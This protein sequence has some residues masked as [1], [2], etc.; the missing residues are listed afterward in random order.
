MTPEVLDLMEERRKAKRKEQKYSEIGR[1]KKCNEA[2][3]WINDQC[4]EIEKHTVKDSKYKHKKVKEVTG[5]YSSSR[6]GCL[7]S[8]AVQILMGKNEI[9]N[10]WSEYIGDLYNDERCRVPSIN[11]G[12]ESFPIMAK[13]VKHALKKMKKG[14]AAGPGY[15]PIELITALHNVGIME[16]M[17]VDGRFLVS[18][19][20]QVKYLMT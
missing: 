3:K 5:K 13:E 17:E 8:K 20:T 19:T 6:M 11:N 18:Y 15:V 14:K 1:Q 7:Q 16:V 9:S 4:I 10:R 2:E 12:I